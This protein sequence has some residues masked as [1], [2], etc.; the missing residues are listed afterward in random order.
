MSV[1]ITPEF[2]KRMEK[3]ETVGQMSEWEKRRQDVIR[4]LIY[5]IGLN[6]TA[7]IL[8]FDTI[9]PAYQH[10][11]FFLF[12]I[13]N[14]D[15]ENF[16][17]FPIWMEREAQTLAETV[18]QPPKIEI[19][20]DLD[21]KYGSYI[22]P[23]TRTYRKKPLKDK[24]WLQRGIKVEEELVRK[25]SEDGSEDGEENQASILS[26]APE[27]FSS[28]HYDVL[29]DK[30]GLTDP[31]RAGYLVTDEEYDLEDGRK[32]ILLGVCG[33]NKTSDPSNYTIGVISKP[34]DRLIITSTLF[35]KKNKCIFVSSTVLASSTGYTI[36]AVPGLNKDTT[37]DFVVFVRSGPDSDPKK[38][39]IVVNIT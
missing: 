2:R 32:H 4:T 29:L 19:P 24:F 35:K 11:F 18:S 25:I 27:A 10:M 22:N 17:T 21:H 5:E 15:A 20:A 34:N 16:T 28:S 14:L 8:F 38:V 39:A 7:A 1:E 33:E 31:Q 6:Y 23:V 26:F 12:V 36:I 3:I 30:M 37:G 13:N 9:A